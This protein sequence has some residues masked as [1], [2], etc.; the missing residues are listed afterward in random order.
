[1]LQSLLAVPKKGLNNI[2]VESAVSAAKFFL[3]KPFFFGRQLVVV[4]E[5]PIQIHVNKLAASNG[6]VDGTS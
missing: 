5:G 1:M 3:C 2:K 4:G 6:G